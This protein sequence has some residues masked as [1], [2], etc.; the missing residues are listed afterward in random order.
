VNLA[1]L[2][3]SLQV[4]VVA[5][6]VAG[7]L[8][9]GT[10]A[11][12]SRMRSGWRD[13][14][15]ALLTAPMVLPPT[16]L[17]W[18]LLVVLGRSGPVGRVFEAVFGG[19]IVFSPVALVVAGIVAAL[20][21][22]VKS[23]R[24]AF[25]DVDPRVVAAANTLGA[26]PWRVLFAVVLPLSRGGVVA[27]LTLGFARALGDFGVTLMIA[28]NIPGHTQTASLALYDAVTA[29]QDDDALGLGLVLCAV[30]I[31]A[32]VVGGRLGQRRP[33]AW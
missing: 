1:P 8:G 2:W 16:V 31:A 30:G 12:L 26:S 20:P 21:F 24:T 15:E 11:L 7:V 28:G 27:G 29:G 25:D 23:S 17:G 19:P 18:L 9:V 13:V 32:L 5:T 3:L 14:I 10:A 6:A 22:V 33:H 4:A